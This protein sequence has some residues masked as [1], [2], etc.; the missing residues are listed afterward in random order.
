MSNILKGI[1]NETSPHDY[2]SDWDYQDAVARSGKSRSSYRSQ[3]D[4][5]FDADVAYSKKMYQLG[6]QQ[7]AA[8]EKAQRDSDHDRLATGTNESFNPYEPVMI[9]GY[10]KWLKLVNI[11]NVDK[12]AYKSDITAVTSLG[13]VIGEFNTDKD[14]GYVIKKYVK[15][16]MSEAG[17]GLDIDRSIPGRT[18]ARISGDIKHRTG[19][20]SGKKLP[21][22][23]P[24]DDYDQWS[25]KVGPSI[26]DDEEDTF[27]TD[28]T[29]DEDGT[30]KEIS[31]EK[32]A[33]YKTAAA[34]DAGKADK[35]GDYKRGDKRFSGIVKAT[36]KQFANDT[37]QSAISQGV[38]EEFRPTTSQAMNIRKQTTKKMNPG[39]SKL[40]WKRPNQIS[41]SHSEN[42]LKSL[43][44][45]YSTKYNMWGGTQDMWNRLTGA[46]DENVGDHL[47][48]TALDV[49]VKAKLEIERQRE[50]IEKQHEAE[51]EAYKQDL[52]KNN[53]SRLP[54]QNIKT[55]Q[56]IPVVKPDENPDVLRDRL[57]HLDI[58]KQKFQKLNELVDA[59]RNT[60]QHHIV[61]TKMDELDKSLLQYVKDGPADNYKSLL[62]K[63]TELVSNLAGQYPTAV[64]YL[65]KKNKQG[66]DEDNNSG[67]MRMK[68][69]YE[70]ADAIQEKLRQ[71]IKMGDTIR[72]QELNKQRDELDARV[73]KH[74]MMPESVDEA[75]MNRRGF[76]GKAGAGALAAAGLGGA[77][78][79][80]AFKG[81]LPAPA[82]SISK[83]EAE[84]QITELKSTAYKELA[85]MMW[86]A[87][88]SILDTTFGANTS[89]D[90]PA[91]PEQIGK[92]LG[93]RLAEYAEEYRQKVRAV[94]VAA[95]VR[96]PQSLNK[97][98]ATIY[99]NE[100][101]I[102][103]EQLDELSC[104]SGYT[105]VQGVPAGA[106]GSCKK[107]TNEEQHS[108]SCPHCGG[109]M[110][111][112]ELMNEKKDACY[113]KVKSR[114]K[115]WPS[116]YASGALVKCRNKGASNWGNGGKKNESSILAGINRA[117][118]SL[119]DWFNKEKWVRMDTK[120][121]IKGPCAREPGEGKP[122]CLPQSKA[123]SLGKKGRASAAQRKRREDPNPD[124]SGK[125][126]NVDTKKKD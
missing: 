8:K 23:H 59:I 71:A 93:Y 91:T 66:V 101:E 57:Q 52:I 81:T 103:E 120:G 38:S 83:D 82:P 48:S 61:T 25:G 102:D 34:L 76:L 116:A 87:W 63:L 43:N 84:A 37:K 86:M 97:T 88:P 111:S 69:Y 4:D 98:T 18:I 56:P 45:K 85:R 119:H 42:E 78:N 31:N 44:F 77:S 51:G 53:A 80:Q 5:T 96:D 105:R 73:K 40:V 60:Y 106:P 112:E 90:K 2:D 75:D 22:Y 72:M 27:D 55:F 9:Q 122:K 95:G 33:Q 26:H 50:A 21:D 32:L 1:I 94:K 68:D 67:R 99:I 107:K 10:D 65:A 13:D 113:Y 39:T 121:K 36:K 109:E 41:G 20:P 6:Q 14:L 124:R 115:V 118:E 30:L 62:I 125:A 89:A 104:W 35:E 7:K 11:P 15:K 74:G 79:A 92:M 100:Q 126:I 16:G 29:G 54:K 24:D 17:T 19:S 110:V 46:L 47:K 123:H 114:Y 58:A 117:D 28:Y 3:E 70:L 64:A 12:H 108:E 49:L